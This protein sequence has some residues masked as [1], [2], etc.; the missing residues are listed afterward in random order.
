MARNQQVVRQ[1][2]ILRRIES[3]PGGAR[4]VDL[5]GCGYPESARRTLYR[6]FKALEEAGFPLYSS[7]SGDDCRWQLNDTYRK[8]GGPPLPLSEII[9]LRCARRTLDSLE[10]TPF[11]EALA[12]L[13]DKLDS[14]LTPA[15]RAF[16][17]QLD[18]LVVADR[19]AQPAIAEL[20]PLIAALS[21]ARAERRTLELRYQSQRG[22]VTERRI[23]PYH[24]WLHRGRGYVVAWC[25]LRGAIRTFA[26]QRIQRLEPIADPDAEP[27]SIQ[28][29][30]DFDSYVADRFRI[31][32]DEQPLDVAIRFAPGAALYISERTWHPTQQITQHE[33]GSI[34][35]TMTT[36][37]LPELTTWV[38]SFGPRA[39][40]LRPPA[41]VDAVQSELRAALARY[42]QEL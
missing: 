11:H 28:P 5:L 25:H 10:Q 42:R 18:Q 9:A 27:F 19:F 8:K 15:M 23:D 32:G 39:T 37:G 14:Y 4:I 29:G 21:D 33:G 26:L 24:L 22:D 34:T 20:R 30:Y 6:D 41:L 36:A 35:L 16:A 17:E 38:L 2:K 3:T 31:F 12:S 13:I 7:G 40:A 1:W